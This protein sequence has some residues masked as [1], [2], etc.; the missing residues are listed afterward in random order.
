MHCLKSI[1][2]QVK[3][4]KWV[5]FSNTSENGVGFSN[6]FEKSAQI[7]PGSGPNISNMFENPI[8]FSYLFEKTYLFFRFDLNNVQF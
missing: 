2:V 1:N 3:S 8:P 7:R 4:G 6:I 5:G